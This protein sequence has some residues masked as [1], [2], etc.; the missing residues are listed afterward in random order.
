MLG[1]VCRRMDSGVFSRVN[2][3]CHGEVVL[4]AADFAPLF[5]GASL[6]NSFVLFGLGAFKK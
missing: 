2:P 5:E 1:L 4:T 3:I 6:E